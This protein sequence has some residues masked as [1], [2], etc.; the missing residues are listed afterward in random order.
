[1]KPDQTTM[2]LYFELLKYVNQD[3][4]PIRQAKKRE[5]GKRYREKNKEKIAAHRK[6]Y[7][8]KNSDKIRAAK[9]RYREANKDTVTKYA[10]NYRLNH[11]EQYNNYNKTY[12]AKKK[13]EKQKELDE[14]ENFTL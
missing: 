6:K 9:K 2:Q 13:A 8:Q 12:R 3:L 10:T 14:I 11:K 1:V 4:K 7:K 5:Q